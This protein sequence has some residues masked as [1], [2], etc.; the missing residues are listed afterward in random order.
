MTEYA[1]GNSL[2]IVIKRIWIWQYPSEY[3]KK[4]N[5]TYFI[6]LFYLLLLKWYAAEN[7]G[8]LF[9]EKINTI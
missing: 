9:K 1:L 6:T 3:I 2:H 5:I 7:D 8:L 4:I